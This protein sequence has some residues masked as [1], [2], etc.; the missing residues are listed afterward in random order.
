MKKSCAMYYLLL[1][2]MLLRAHYLPAQTVEQYNSSG[3]EKSKSGNYYEAEKDFNSGVKKSDE[4][5]ALVYHNLGWSYEQQGDLKN[6]LINYEEAIKR[7]SRQIVS[8]ERA[9]YVSYKL[10]QH[11]KAV[12]IGEEGMRLDP[13]NEEIPTWLTSAY[14]E[15]YSRNKYLL[16]DPNRTFKPARR[17]VFTAGAA[18]F[19]PLG[20][21]TDDY[22][23]EYL[24]NRGPFGADFSIEA[25][26][27]Y[28]HKNRWG[29][30]LYV[31]NP[32]FG[33]LM[34]DTIFL[35]E[36]LEGYIIG[37]AHYVGAGLMVSHYQGDHHFSKDMLLHDFKIGIVYGYENDKNRL[38]M[39]WYPRLIPHET[40]YGSERYLD[41]ALL[42]VDWVRAYRRSFD[43]SFGFKSTEF[44]FFDNKADEPV[45]DY[46]GVYEVKA[47]VIFNNNA[48]AF[49]RIHLHLIERIYMS[50]YNNR[51]P[52]SSFNGQGMFGINTRKWLKGDPL[53]G[54]STLSHVISAKFEQRFSDNFVLYEKIM[55]E[56]VMPSRAYHGAAL[57]IGI[58]GGY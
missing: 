42:E 18:I 55:L 52:Y 51:N 48:S 26:G 56:A 49:H 25:Y 27:E 43:L 21:S 53:S 58:E 24:D 32:Y 19:G 8:Y 17:N 1:T 23:V 3:V 20:I 54:I 50:D 9:G 7:N 6:A 33:T 47:G 28:N 36:R 35:T 22:S 31:G 2:I 41:T 13:T 46:N 57:Q 16:D 40:G 14:R 37:E 39:R 44:Y 45:S 30:R 4:G 10:G 29:A 5:A 11:Q 15:R 34:P 38:D 12:E